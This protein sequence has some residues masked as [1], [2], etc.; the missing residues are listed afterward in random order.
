MTRRAPQSLP[1]ILENKKRWMTRLRRAV[2]MLTKLD[3]AEL[4]A[5]AK[6]LEEKKLKRKRVTTVKQSDGLDIPHYLQR[7]KPVDD[8][9]S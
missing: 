7:I 6:A 5:S 8:R 9:H 2:T 4:R 1:L 3:A